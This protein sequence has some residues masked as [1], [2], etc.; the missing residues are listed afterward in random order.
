V[1]GRLTGSLSNEKT[2]IFVES[3]NGTWHIN[4]QRAAI[5]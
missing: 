2:K 5:Q 4:F 3:I 1:K